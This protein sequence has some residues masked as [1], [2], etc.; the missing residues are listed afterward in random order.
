MKH[1]VSEL[2]G[3]PLDIAVAIAAGNT[4][5]RWNWGPTPYMEGGVGQPGSN[6]TLW[7]PSTDW[8]QGGPIIASE[9]ITVILHENGSATAEVRAYYDS[10][11]IMRSDASEQGDTPLIAAMR[12]YVSNKLGAEIE[13][14]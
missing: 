12:A 8:A 5:V 14:P 11:E 9:R 7:S 1:T 10:G 13:L 6:V 2:E 4:A 3:A